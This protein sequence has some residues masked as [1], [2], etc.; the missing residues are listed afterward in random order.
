MLLGEILIQKKLI[1]PQQLEA[2]L[3]LQAET[4]E[5]LGVILV[6]RR[7]IKEEDL[8]KA[9]SEQF[10]I[11]IVKLKDN[12]IDW[13]ASMKFSSSVVCEYRC[14]PV[15]ADSRSITVAITNPLDA[16]AISKVEEEARE[17]K[18]ELVLVSNADMDEA[19]KTYNRYASQKIKKMLE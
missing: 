17:Y 3:K 19:L 13:E 5:F 16:I 4:K 8:L 10:N 2:A 18:V 1:T 12:Y 7:Y 11:P 14:L 9:L 15:R 6:Q